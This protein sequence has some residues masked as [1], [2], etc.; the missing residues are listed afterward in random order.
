MSST[1]TTTPPAPPPKRRR[2]DETDLTDWTAFF[3]ALL[4][5]G[6]GD[7]CKTQDFV[8]WCDTAALHALDTVRRRE[9]EQKDCTCLLFRKFHSDDCEIHALEA[10]REEAG[11]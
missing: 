7:D 11:L 6:A 10:D 8:A 9:R 1:K 4:S 3:L 2:L 5:S